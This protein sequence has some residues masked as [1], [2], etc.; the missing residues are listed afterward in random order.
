MPF[1]DGLQNWTFKG[2]AAARRIDSDQ[3]WEE[4]FEEDT[5]LSIEPILDSNERYI[6]IGGTANG[7]LQLPFAFA[8]LADRA[9]FLAQRGTTGVLARLGYNPKSRVAV[10]RRAQELASGN[11]AFY[12]LACTFEAL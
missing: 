12:L 1:L 8:T 2:I 7:A 6:D 10:F 11:D 9:A 5:I 4:W 3:E